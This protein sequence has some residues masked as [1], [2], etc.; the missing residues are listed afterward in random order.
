M[1]KPPSDRR[2]ITAHLV[3][4]GGV[5]AVEWYQKALGGELVT[6]TP[7][8]DGKLMHAELKFG[9]C[10]LMLADSCPERGM[11]SPL[12]LGGSPV[13]INLLVPD[14]DRVW[15]QAV[16]AGAT[17]RFPLNDMFWGDRYGQLTDPFGHV[18]AILTHK[19]DVPPEEMEKRAKA[20]MAQMK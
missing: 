10:S 4:S 7:M 1:P 18:W 5:K 19:E 16:A 3:V 9:D 20:A 14:C 8:Q 12:D 15:E 6:M 17:V 13:V 11:K 2:S